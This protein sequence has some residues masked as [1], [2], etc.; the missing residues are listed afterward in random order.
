MSARKLTAPQLA[1]LR[2]IAKAVDELEPRVLASLGM[3]LRGIAVYGAGI[4]AATFLAL[5]RAGMVEGESR[6]MPCVYRRRG[7][8]VQGEYVEWWVRPTAAGR[9]ALAEAAS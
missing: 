5:L 4:K 2:K 9:A 6:R 7:Y 3:H 8:D 1:A